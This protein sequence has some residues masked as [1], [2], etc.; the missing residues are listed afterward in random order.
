[1]TMSEKDK[2]TLI[3]AVVALLIFGI[4]FLGIKPA[5]SSMKETKATNAELSAQKEEMKTEIESLPTYKANYEQAKVDYKATTDRIFPSHDNDE[6][7][8]DIVALI[9]E[10]GMTPASVNI[11]DTTNMGMQYYVATEESSTGG[12]AEGDVKMVS[13]SASAFGTQDQLIAFVDI[14]N[15]NE[16]TYLQQVSFTES[17]EQS[18][19]SVSFMMVLADTF[20]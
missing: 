5:F 11:A 18:A 13:I 16:G 4:A 9:R 20:E 6:L 3:I 17:A 19:Y 7:H 2:N 12:V 15:K 10:A 8:D 1:M 14:L